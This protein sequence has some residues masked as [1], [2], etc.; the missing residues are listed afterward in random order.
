MSVFLKKDCGF[1]QRFTYRYYLQMK[2][3]QMKVYVGW[4]LL[5]DTM[6]EEGDG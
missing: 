4:G 2:F 5:P 3:F 1:F 6:K